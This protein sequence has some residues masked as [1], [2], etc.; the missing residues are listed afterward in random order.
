MFVWGFQPWDYIDCKR[1]P[2]SRYVF[3]TF[4]MGYVPWFDEPEE[5]ERERMTPGS[6]ELLVRE[7]EA[8]KPAVVI[9]V[10]IGWRSMDR[11]PDLAPFLAS[12]CLLTTD[13]GRRVFVRE[14]TCH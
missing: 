11:Y 7:L 4:V 8:T 5:K 10:P 13:G 14:P 1:K 3:T 2:A 12:Y 9:D 6:H